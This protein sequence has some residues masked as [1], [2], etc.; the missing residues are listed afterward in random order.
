MPAS[1]PKTIARDLLKD[2]QID[3]KVLDDVSAQLKSAK[4]NHVMAKQFDSRSE[5][6]RWSN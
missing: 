4:R 2:A 3:P 6:P 1:D 5:S